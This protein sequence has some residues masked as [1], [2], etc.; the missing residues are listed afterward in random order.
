MFSRSRSW[1]VVGLISVGAMACHRSAPP[2][3]PGPMQ[4]A[5][6]AVD[7]AAGNVKDAAHDT[8]QAVKNDLKK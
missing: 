1:L 5:G 2:Q 6:A 7:H 3:S 8:G 4:K